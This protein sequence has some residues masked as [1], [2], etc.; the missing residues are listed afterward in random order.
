VTEREVKDALADDG[1]ELALLKRK[2]LYYHE[3]VRSKPLPFF[4]LIVQ[5]L[6]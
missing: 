1:K 4:A 6:A 5:Q 2:G 3:G